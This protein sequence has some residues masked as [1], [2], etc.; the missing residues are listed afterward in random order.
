[1]ENSYSILLF[2]NYVA[3]DNPDQLHLDQLSLCKRLNLKGRIIVAHEGINATLEG[4]DSMIDEY[5][6]EFLADPRFVDTDI[7]RD[8]G[9][10]NA[11]PKLSVKIRSELVSLHLDNSD[12]NPKTLTGKRV[13][14]DE[15]HALYES[16]AEFTVVDMRN[17]Y[18]YQSGHFRGARLPALKHFRDLPNVISELED[19]KDKKI[20]TVCTGGV[21]CEKA[22]GYLLSQ[23]FKD[24]SQ[25]DGGIV[26]YMKRYPNQHFLGSLYV[27]DGRV[28]VSYDDGNH[29][30]I[31]TCALCGAATETYANCS[32]LNCHDHFLVCD[33]CPDHDGSVYCS[34]S[35]KAQNT[36]VPLSLSNNNLF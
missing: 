2:Y 18:E 15:L 23:G 9:T 7:K 27:F 6:A 13:T 14:P 33:A 16:G 29:T 30:V 21:R 3:I 4:K 17:E 36:S 19:L 26:S 5:L 25:L 12:I 11:F 10:G 28:S 31:G 34:T 8:S 22:S 24:V 20:V 32:N 1:M 35:C